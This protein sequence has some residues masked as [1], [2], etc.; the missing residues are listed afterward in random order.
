M[1][2]LRL[3]DFL[4]AILFENDEILAIDKPYGFN[5]HTNDSKAHHQDFIQ[6][7]LVEIFQKQLG[8]PLYVIHRLDQTTTG[9]M[10]FGKTQEATKKYAEFFFSR[11]VQKTYLF[12]TGHASS[13]KEFHVEKEII[14]KGKELDAQTDLKFLNKTGS[15]ELWQ[16]NPHTGRNHQIRLHA[17]TVGLSILGDALYD[18]KAFPFL[19]LHNRRIEFPNGIVIE[20][21]PPQYFEK[22]EYL[23]DLMLAK[24]LFEIDRR[25]RI[26]A[27]LDK[28]LQAMR[29]V[30]NKNDFDDIGFTIDQF[31]PKWVLSWY[32]EHWTETDQKRFS[33]VAD[34]YNRTIVVRL[35]YNR[36]KDPVHKSQL[37]I[38]PTAL[39]AQSELSSKL[40]NSWMAL[41]NE[42]QY[43]IR[44]DSGQS[45][46]LFLDQRLQRRWVLGNSNGKSVLNLFCYT[47]GFS[48]AA[49]LGGASQVTSVDT[50]KNVVNWGRKNFQINDLD[51]QKHVFLCRD[52]IDFL[53]KS[54]SKNQKYD[55]I[56]CDPPSFSR[57]E[58]GV[59][60]IENSLETLLENCLSCLSENGDLFFSTNFENIYITDIKQSILNVQKKLKIQN[61]E[62]NNI[63]SAFDFEV[64]GKKTILKSFLIRRK[65]I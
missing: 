22:M 17:Q 41:E 27:F 32:A 35:M 55:L 14:H 10:V 45:F 5:A 23:N 61:L 34:L 6:D 12:V 13:K 31:G 24:T 28:N 15:F 49:A 9:V 4:L 8:Y 57:G 25:Q 44:T 43:E 56:V 54:A 40:E 59:F 16:A 26:F 38:F 62:I 64:P 48:V 53:Q 21:N 39:N 46:G 50:N 52:S 19:C 33:L 30:H 37:T 1:N 11:Q 3:N 63:Q 36:G 60:K 58:K 65:T 29:L 42:I 47:C 7:G 51:D 20:S 2:F 18:G